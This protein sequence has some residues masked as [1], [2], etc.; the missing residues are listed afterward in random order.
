MM[1]AIIESGGKQYIIKEGD[2]VKIEKL[3][4][5]KDVIFDKVLFLDTEKEKLVGTPFLENVKI[6]GEKVED[7]KDKKIIVFKKKAK[8]GYKKKT[9]HRQTYSFV[10]I[11]K[12]EVEA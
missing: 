8:K 5:K 12:I 9:G 6:L 3:N 7:K 1:Y 2:I 10:K 11:K 4:A